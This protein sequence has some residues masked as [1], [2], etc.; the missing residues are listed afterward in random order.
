[1][2]RFGGRNVSEGRGDAGIPAQV[3]K[4]GRGVSRGLRRG[5]AT[6]S[7]GASRVRSR[8]TVGRRSL[9]VAMLCPRTMP[10]PRPE[11]GLD[12][13]LRLIRVLTTEILPHQRDPSL[14]QIQRGSEGVSGR[15]RC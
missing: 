11:P 1:M 6:P 10:E 4:K 3:E 13:R 12:L 7:L 9:A 8:A 5:S 15:H 14:E 2:P